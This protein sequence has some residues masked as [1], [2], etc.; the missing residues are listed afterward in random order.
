MHQL[1]HAMVLLSLFWL[2][3]E[4]LAQFFHWAFTEQGLSDL[5]ISAE[6]ENLYCSVCSAEGDAFSSQ[7]SMLC[8]EILA[9]IRIM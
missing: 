3:P 4:G 5:T 1:F 9:D 2:T 7:C 6:P 8:T